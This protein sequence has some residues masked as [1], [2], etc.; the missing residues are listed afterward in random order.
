MFQSKNMF[1]EELLLN[2]ILATVENYGKY[3]IVMLVTDN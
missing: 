3:L 2:V 1:I